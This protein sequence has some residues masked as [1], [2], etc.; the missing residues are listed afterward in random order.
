MVPFISIYLLLNGVCLFVQIFFVCVC[1][2]CVC[3]CVCGCVCV[4]VCVALHT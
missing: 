1:R 4:C 3:V 2:V